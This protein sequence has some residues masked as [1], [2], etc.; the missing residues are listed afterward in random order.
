MKLIVAVDDNFAIGKDGG[1]P[2]R[3]RGDLMYFKEKSKLFNG[4]I[5][6]KSM[7]QFAGRDT[8]VCDKNL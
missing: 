4:C 7:D 8:L 6:Y 1:I 5:R 2:W 3:L